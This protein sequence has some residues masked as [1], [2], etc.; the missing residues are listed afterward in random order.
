[1]QTTRF[2]AY[3]P[4]GVTPRHEGSLTL[5]PLTKES[6]LP[7]LERLL[8]SDELSLKTI[9]ALDI[10]ATEH[11]FRILY[12]FG[13]PESHTYLVPYFDTQ[14]T[15]PSLARIRQGCSFYEREIMTM[16]GLRPEGGIDTRLTMAPVSFSAQE[17]PLR[18]DATIS[19]RTDTPDPLAEYQF[20][21]VQGDA[22]YEI[23][24]GPVHAGIIEPGH[25]RF[26]VFGEEIKKLDP[27]L[28]W[29]HK[30][31]EKLFE[32]GSLAQKIAI[33]ERVSGD[34]SFAHSL[35]LCQ[36]LESLSHVQ[37]HEYTRL[38]RVLFAEMERLANHFS[39]IGFIMLDT[40][41]T[42]GGSNGARLRER[43]MQWAE[44]ITGSRFL[45][46]VNT[47][48]GLACTLSAPELHAFLADIPRIRTDFTEVIGIA[49]DSITLHQ[50][51]VTTGTLTPDVAQDFGVVGIP[52][53]A[54]GSTRDARKDFPYAAYDTLD[55]KVVTKETGDVYARFHVRIGEVYESL[56]L[57]EQALT[58]LVRIS[59]HA[60][61]TNHH[62]RKDAL[63]VSMVEGWRGD[64]VYVVT[65]NGTGEISRIKVR[66]PSF[67]NWQAFPNAAVGEMVPD[68]PLIN[69]SF[70]LSYSG[71]D[72]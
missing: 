70:N 24:V 26:S 54:V 10:R 60:H 53:R 58:R 69:K 52:A 4:S 40:A 47:I 49:N 14:D 51:L 12:V 33:A 46:G 7:T 50:R 45:R 59:P 11:T 15:F 44:R 3:I 36:A 13:H 42:F 72:L 55:F 48:G 27:L 28:G 38:A 71:N 34:S 18:K 2:N 41:F 66:D 31:I 9:T 64:I 5:F 8:T 30:G 62:V 56:S 57:I 43:M 29:K 63:A 16:F 39:D 65:T 37:P 68:F 6:F 67:L 1:M 17:Y 23:P 61:E 21:V 22:V 25:F 19:P 35:A 32:T 20:S